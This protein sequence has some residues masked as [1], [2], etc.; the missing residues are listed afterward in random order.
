MIERK[1]V[2]IVRWSSHS[3]KLVAP[4]TQ[5]LTCSHVSTICSKYGPSAQEDNC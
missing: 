4:T 2:P 1:M 3:L 5:A